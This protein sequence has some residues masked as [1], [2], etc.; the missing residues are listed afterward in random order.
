MSELT[1]WQ[2]LAAALEEGREVALA[3]VVESRGS[4][5]GRAGDLMAVGAE[6]LLAGTVGGGAPERRM[7]AHLVAGLGRGDLTPG[8]VQLTHRAQAE[9]ASGL[10]CGGEQWVA[11]APLSRIDQV[12]AV[13]T[14]L[15]TGQRISWTIG[16]AGWAL[17]DAATASGEHLLL[18][19]PSHEVWVIGG[20]HVGRA[21]TRVLAGL[22]FWVVVADERPE[23]ALSNPWAHRRVP[24][25]FA[26]V[27]RVVPPGERTF[28][29]IVT[30]AVESDA[31]ALDALWDIPLGYLGV[32]GSRAKLAQ[33]LAGRGKRPAWLHAPMGVPIGSHTPAEIAVSVAAELVAVRQGRDR[34]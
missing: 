30:A 19:G 14:A 23:V 4:S 8:E 28:V 18:S 32:M 34:R 21:L 29:A 9:M 31:A 1:V 20:G 6:G 24:V 7:I 5:P 26:E 25:P 17:A 2:A 33:L 22:D 12:R 3:V 13:V 27:G 10:V 15:A 11:W 16:P